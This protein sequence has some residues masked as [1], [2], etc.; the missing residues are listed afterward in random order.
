MGINNLASF[1]DTFDVLK[2][3]NSDPIDIFVVILLFIRC[4]LC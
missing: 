3:K 2:I 4:F 1:K